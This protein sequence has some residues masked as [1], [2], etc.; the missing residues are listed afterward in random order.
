MDTETYDIIFAGDIRDWAA[1]SEVPEHIQPGR[2]FRNLLLNQK[3]SSTTRSSY[4]GTCRPTC[5]SFFWMPVGG[6]SSVNFTT[7][8]RAA[9]SDYDDWEQIY[10]KKV[11]DRST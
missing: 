6:G 10:G 2:Y 8:T 9:A 1:Y 4:R 5:C 7:Y 11:G 3:H